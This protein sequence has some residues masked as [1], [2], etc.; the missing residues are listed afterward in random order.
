MLVI[1][2][3]GAP[4]LHRSTVSEESPMASQAPFSH[5]SFLRDCGHVSR[6]DMATS[7]SGPEDTGHGFYVSSFPFL[8]TETQG[9]GNAWFLAFTIWKGRSSP[10][11]LQCNHIGSSFCPQVMKRSRPTAVLPFLRVRF[12]LSLMG[13]HCYDSSAFTL[14]RKI[15]CLRTWMTYGPCATCG[16]SLQTMRWLATGNCW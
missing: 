11:G 12:Y 2:G 1:R 13:S 5:W 8:I 14:L 9:Y 10:R 6:K 16:K 15:R 7:C 4:F 3:R